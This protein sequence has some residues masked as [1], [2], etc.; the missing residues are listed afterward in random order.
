MMR[1]PRLASEEPRKVGRIECLLAGKPRERAS[2]GVGT[3]AGPDR[4]Q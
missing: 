4:G 2:Q 1:D 3:A